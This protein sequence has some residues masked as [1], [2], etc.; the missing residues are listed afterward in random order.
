MTKT[1]TPRD[2]NEQSMARH[3]KRERKRGRIR[4]NEMKKMI[5]KNRQLNQLLTFHTE[6]TDY[7]IHLIW[8]QSHWLLEISLC[9]RAD[10]VRYAFASPA[11]LIPSSITSAF[12]SV[13]CH[14]DGF[15]VEK[16]AHI[17]TRDKW[18][19]WVQVRI[20]GGGF[21]CTFNTED[22]AS[23]AVIWFYST[24]CVYL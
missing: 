8:K 5:E 10:G 17:C 18:S 21:V 20:G 2:A 19:M 1:P 11:L 24:C 7:T 13:P 16:R 6:K 15:N 3:R 14:S 22:R 4:T 23:R 12:F 9:S